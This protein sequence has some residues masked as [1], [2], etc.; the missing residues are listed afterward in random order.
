M[1]PQSPPL[2][3]YGGFSPVRL[4]MRSYTGCPSVRRRLTTRSAFLRPPAFVQALV[5]SRRGK[6]LTA[7]T[8]KSPT[9]PTGPWLSAVCHPRTCKRYYGL[10]RQSG[11]LPPV[12]ELSWSVFALPGRPPHLPLFALTHDLRPCHY[13]YPA[14]G[15]SSLDGSSL[16]P[17]S[18]RLLLSGS[19]VSVCPLTGF[20]EVC[21]SRQPYSR[22]VA[23][24]T[25]A[26]AADQSPPTLSCR[27]ARPFTA[28]LAP[29]RISPSQSLLSLLGPTT[30]CRGR[31]RTRSRIKER[32]LHQEATEET[33]II[34][35][36]CREIRAPSL[37]TLLPPVK[38]ACGPCNSRSGIKLA[39]LS[40]AVE[41]EVH[42]KSCVNPIR[43]V[44][45]VQSVVTR[46]AVGRL[47]F[48]LGSLSV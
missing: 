7:V 32:R 10:M 37:L 19:A 28:E 2:I 36:F 21:L 31:I 5:A 42:E 9:T 24:C 14:D 34:Q 46:P 44:A 25:L 16:G 39:T 35:S 23:A 45:S 30:Y 40:S 43:S 13:P 8:L 1:F 38:G 15:P 17:R 41:N 12:Y 6:H 20:R 4:E 48:R 47:G 3:P 26:R 29:A 18:L 27:Q 11:G 33:E 22:H